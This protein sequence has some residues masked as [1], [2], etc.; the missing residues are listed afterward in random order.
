MIQTYRFCQRLK[1]KRNRNFSFY[2]THRPNFINFRTFQKAAS[3]LIKHVWEEVQNEAILEFSPWK[4]VIMYV[5]LVG[6]FFKL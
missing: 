4:N 3:D 5:F 1:N 6:F 2:V